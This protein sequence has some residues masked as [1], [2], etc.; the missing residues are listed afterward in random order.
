MNFRVY[1]GRR[2]KRFMLGASD[3]M[4]KIP[5][6]AALQVSGNKKT[7]FISSN[8]PW[9]GQ[10]DIENAAEASQNGWFRPSSTH[11][12]S[13]LSCGSVLLL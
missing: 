11:F 6:K 2:K 13:V 10:M 8:R 5:M 9:C 4:V 12:D 1:V 3:G 7:N